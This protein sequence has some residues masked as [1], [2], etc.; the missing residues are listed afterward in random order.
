MNSFGTQL[1]VNFVLNDYLYH[2]ETGK[3]EYVQS[4]DHTS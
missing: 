3:A 1:T 4:V 2:L